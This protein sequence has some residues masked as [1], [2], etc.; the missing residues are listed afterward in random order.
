MAN[1]SD[2]TPE[3]R[4]HLSSPPESTVRRYLR[5]AAKQFC[6][7]SLVWDRSIGT[8]EVEANGSAERSIVLHDNGATGDGRDFVAPAQ[9]WI[10]T[11]S[12]VLHTSAGAD[13]DAERDEVDEAEYRFEVDERALVLRPGA[14]T[15]TGTLD[16]RAALEPTRAAVTVPDFLVEQ[17]GEG[18]ADYAVFEMLTMP[19]QEW[20]DP[21]LALLFERKYQK[22]VSE[23]RTHKARQGTRKSI[24]VTPFPFI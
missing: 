10:T 13:F 7:D 17:F 19:K 23:A 1:L 18:I 8:A 4:S 22:R 20:S 2:L 3:V 21:D 24:E 16:V 12:R 6:Q 11:V 15:S 9:A 5:R 14:I